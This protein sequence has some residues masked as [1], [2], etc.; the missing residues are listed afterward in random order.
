MLG[1]G[2]VW[3]APHIIDLSPAGEIHPHV[4]SIKRKI[5]FDYPKGYLYSAIDSDKIIAGL[6]LISHREMRLFRNEE[7]IN[8]ENRITIDLPPRSLY[9]LQNEARYDLAHAIPKSS[10]LERRISIIFRD[11]LPPPWE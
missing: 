10:S 2:L 7:T 11:D 1:Q 9:L 6:S 5:V 3:L 4:D 8:E